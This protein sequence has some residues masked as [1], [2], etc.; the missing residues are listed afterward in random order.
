M[1]FRN[2]N[3]YKSKNYWSE[4]VELLKYLKVLLVQRQNNSTQQQISILNEF[5][6]I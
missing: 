4:I 6:G 1:T 2:K 3:K 5:L